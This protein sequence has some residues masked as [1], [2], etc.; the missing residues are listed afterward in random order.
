[1]FPMARQTKQPNMIF[2]RN[3][4]RLPH[5]TLLPR[6]QSPISAT[7]A[8]KERPTR[9]GV[10]SGP[11]C[12]VFSRPAGWAKYRQRRKTG[13][14]KHVQPSGLGGKAGSGS[15][16]RF[17]SSPQPVRGTVFLAPQPFGGTGRDSPLA[18]SPLE[19]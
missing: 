9:Y 2:L 13:G 10:G 12:C 19:A 18:P 17:P 11:G 14:E 8:G 16:P 4:N 6:R 7:K 1:P 5:R 15:L 3:S